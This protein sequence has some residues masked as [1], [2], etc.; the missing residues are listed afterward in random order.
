MRGILAAVAG[1]LL[2]TAASLRAEEVTVEVGHNRLSPAELSISVGDTVTFKN[3]DRMPG[4]HSVA[5][6]D[7][8]FRSPALDAGASW[9]HTFE[10]AG[11]YPYKIVEHPG[12]TGTIEVE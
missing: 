1:A 2:L 6:D 12:T 7:G 10:E 9:S 5:A 3:L 11:T 8:S 4:G